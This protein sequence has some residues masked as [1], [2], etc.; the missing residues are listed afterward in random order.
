MK[1]TLLPEPQ[2]MSALMALTVAIPFTAT[3]VTMASSA[4]PVA[5][6][7]SQINPLLQRQQIEEQRREQQIY[8]RAQQTQI[9]AL[10]GVAPENATLPDNGQRFTLSSISITPSVFITKITLSALAKKYIGREISIAD[11]NQLLDSINHLYEQQGQLTA[12]A[13]IPP[14]NVNEGVLHIL[15]VEAKVDNIGWQGRNGRIDNRFYDQRLPIKKQQVLNSPQLMAW[16]QRFNTTSPSPGPKVTAG[17]APGKAFGTTSVDF[18]AFEPAALDWSLFTNNY[19]NLSTGRWQYGGYLSWFSPTGAADVLN[20]T[21]IATTGTQFINLHYGRPVNRYNGIAY[22]EGGYNHFQINHGNLKEL[23]VK[24][25]STVYTLG[26]TQPWWI[27]EHWL[28][29]AGAYYSHQAS[30]SQISGFNLSNISVNDIGL[31]AQ[32]EYR[33]PHWYVR[34]E[35]RIRHDNANNQLNGIRGGHELFTGNGY[36]MRQFDAGLNLVMRFS[37]QLTSSPVKLPSTLDYQLGGVSSVRGY[38]NGILASPEG[39]TVNLESYWNINDN[40][41]PF[42]FYDYGRT[43]KLGLQ[44]LSLQG[45]GAGLNFNWQRW[46]RHLSIGVV[47][48]KA[49]TVITPHQD[50]AQVL[51]QVNVH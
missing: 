2:W 13:M 45:A 28:L 17:L 11:L 24:G 33:R 23:A 36:L 9:P 37:W 35:Q 8:Q 21:M 22:L 31:L 44:D 6:Q 32:M 27:N 29:T 18:T 7:P 10:S 50:K 16:I 49:L 14:Q 5:T 48:A 25:Y 42:I 19:G 30:N 3:A 38:G 46:N 20:S 43:I 47:A 26:Y 40:W 39:A 12:R 34:Y 51:V 15:L 1:I 4:L 41:Q